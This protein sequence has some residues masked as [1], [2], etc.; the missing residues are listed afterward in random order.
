[1][2]ELMNAVARKPAE[3]WWKRLTRSIESAGLMLTRS[4][5]PVFN[6]NPNIVVVGYYQDK[7]HVYGLRGVDY[8]DHQIMKEVG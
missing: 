1:M 4:S 8:T 7:I 2:E 3:L 5:S 6:Q